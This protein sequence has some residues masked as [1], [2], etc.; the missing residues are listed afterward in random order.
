[1]VLEEGTMKV[2]AEAPDGAVLLDLDGAAAKQAVDAATSM[3]STFYHYSLIPLVI[4]TVVLAWQARPSTAEAIPIG[5]RKFQFAYLSVWVFC[6]AADWLQGPYVYALYADY[7]FSRHQIAQLFVA[8][9]A[10]SLVF[11]CVV[12][13]ICDRF[14]RKKCAVAYCVLY[15]ISCLT[16]H[17]KHFGVLMIGRITGGIATSFLFSCF[18]CWMVS[19]HVG[20]RKFSDGLLSYMFGLM[21]T[22]HYLVAIISGIVGEVL[23]DGFKFHPAQP[24]SLIYF[25]GALGPFDLAIVCLL[26][27]SVLIMLLWDENYGQDQNS[28]DKNARPQQGMV[29]NF[30]EAVSLLRSDSRTLFL[31]LA[32]ACFEGSMFAFV[33]NWTPALESKVVPPPYGLIFA[34]FMMSCMCGASIST[35]IAPYVKPTWRLVSVFAVGCGSLIV[36]ALVCNISMLRLCFASFCIFEFCVGIY[37]PSVGYLK[38]EIVPERVRGTMYNL[39]RVP[40]NAVVVAALLT[41]MTIVQ[42]YTFCAVLLGIGMTCVGIVHVSAS[43]PKGD[44]SS[45]KEV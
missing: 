10:S 34:L 42:V 32:V 40:L 5:F 38:S 19:E 7:D 9:F 43:A 22:V 28:D 4:I 30:V 44:L 36:A 39:Y 45:S 20:R 12:G 2:F 11:S 25:G 33:F 17:V 16:K 37:F 1:M 8:G 15:I 26:I 35:L 21:Y 24:G 23:N 3:G 18:E 31:G 29:Q 13:A 14:G 27:G 41:N 6:A